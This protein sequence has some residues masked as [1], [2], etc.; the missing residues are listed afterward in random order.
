M[1]HM[2]DFRS[3]PHP[4]KTLLEE[5]GISIEETARHLGRGVSYVYSMI[6][7]SMYMPPRIEKRLQKLIDSTARWQGGTAS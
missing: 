2:T 3:D 1:I 5:L 6:E 4:L 7:G